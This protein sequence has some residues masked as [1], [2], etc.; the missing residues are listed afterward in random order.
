M[1]SD[2]HVS[3]GNEFFWLQKA[4]FWRAY[5]HCG[6]EAASGPRK[7]RWCLFRNAVLEYGSHRHLENRSNL[8]SNTRSL[9]RNTRK[10]SKADFQRN[11]TGSNDYHNGRTIISNAFT[12]GNTG[13]TNAIKSFERSSKFDF[14]NKGLRT[15]QE[16]GR[17]R[18]GSGENIVEDHGRIIS[19]FLIR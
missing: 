16:M 8:N 5:G 9:P 4:H 18:E 19:L 13:P 7:R 3:L 17:G 11:I 12:R 6:E 15:V 1:R 10:F 2:S 14:T